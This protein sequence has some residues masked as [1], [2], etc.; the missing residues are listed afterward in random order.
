MGG[1]LSDEALVENLI[2]MDTNQS[3][4]D[5]IYRIFNNYAARQIIKIPLPM[6]RPEDKII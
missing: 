6:R 2:D 4:K 1:S 5:L 3:N